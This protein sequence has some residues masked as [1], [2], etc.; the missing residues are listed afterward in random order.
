MRHEAEKIIPWFDSELGW[1]SA[2][3][4]GPL[5]GG[6][7]N[8]TWRFE[9]GDDACVVRTF[10]AETISPTAHRGIER[11]RKV[12][13]AIQGQVKA[14]RVLGWGDEN[15]PL[16]RPFLVVECIDGVSITDALPSAYAQQPDAASRLGE[17]LIDQLAAIHKV[18]LE[19]SGLEDMGRPDKFLER[20]VTRWLGVRREA[21]VRDLPS[22]ESLGQWLLD[23][24]PPATA[25]T[26]VH[27]DYHLDNTLAST[28][29]PEILAVI[30]WE[31]A[32]VGDP[33][34]DL[35]LALMFWGQKR[36]ARPPAFDHLQAI[37]RREDVI[38]RRALA[39][40]WSESTG[41]GLENLDYYM[42]YAFWRLAAIV[43]GAYCLYVAGKVDSAYARGLE[44]NVPALLQEAEQAAKGNW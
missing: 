16:G 19:T 37:S 26:L 9:N 7:S 8:L 35:G 28:S 43:E 18:D 29:A 14:P 20:Q 30:D 17:E 12:L 34:T 25:P 15:S 27:G 41:R 32:S 38:D 10:P 4:T 42:A 40:R 1:S 2:T 23:N 39:E 13:S 44:Y 21:S 31:M 6:N 22:I 36:M 11:E 5:S 33:Y 24:Q 3:F